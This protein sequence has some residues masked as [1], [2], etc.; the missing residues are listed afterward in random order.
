V[1]RERESIWEVVGRRQRHLVISAA[2]GLL[3]NAGRGQRC[4][5]DFLVFFQRWIS[6]GLGLEFERVHIDFGS[7]IGAFRCCWRRQKLG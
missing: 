5:R 7:F 2:F 6:A 4:F 1:G 3:D